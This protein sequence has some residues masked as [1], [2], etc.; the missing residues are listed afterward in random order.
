MENV[1]I[2]MSTYNGEKYLSE[3]LDSLLMQKNVE[4]QIVIRDDGSKDDTLNIIKSYQDR[5]SNISLSACENVGPTTS[6]LELIKNAPEADYYALCDQDDV[7]MD[8]KIEMA[9]LE[10][11]KNTKTSIP[12]LYHSNLFVVDSEL[13][14]I[15]KSNKIESKNKFVSL[16]DNNVTGCTSVLNRE[17]LELIRKHGCVDVTM[18]DAWINIIASFFGKVVFDSN[19]YI[20]YR[21]HER[22]VI[23]MHEHNDV[24]NNLKSGLYR[25]KTKNLQPRLRNALAFYEEFNKTMIESDRKQVEIM[26]NYK[27]TLYNKLK[28]L[29]DFKI[30][31]YSFER[32]FKYRLLILVGEI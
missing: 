30:R 6:F 5:Y 13:N 14:P 12:V 15:M 23:G 10:I 27:K 29:F 4:I 11:K 8:N 9:I 22:N 17:L 28:L 24:F 16:V 25:L 7:W 31:S 1:C 20:Y 18:H 21:Q 2:L 32:D 26:I 3:Q 19:S